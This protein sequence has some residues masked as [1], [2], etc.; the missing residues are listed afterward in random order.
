MFTIMRLGY[1]N[2]SDRD[3]FGTA[4]QW[5]DSDRYRERGRRTQTDLFTAGLNSAKDIA[6]RILVD[7]VCSILLVYPL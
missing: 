2:D 7:G 1:S 6:G 4:F 3:A 5:L